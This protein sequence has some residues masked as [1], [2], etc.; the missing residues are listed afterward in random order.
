MYLPAPVSTVEAFSRLWRKSTRSMNPTQNHEK[1]K[2]KSK[3]GA[4][5]PGIIFASYPCPEL[6]ERKEL[7]SRVHSPAPASTAGACPRLWP[8]PCEAP[9][10]LGAASPR[11]RAAT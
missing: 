3:L 5:M 8:P 10:R 11:H 7:E 9:L 1:K 6:R 2:K 4:A